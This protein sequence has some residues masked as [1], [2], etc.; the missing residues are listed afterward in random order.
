MAKGIESIP[1]KYML[2][3]IVSVMILGA[4]L[5]ILNQ[6]QATSMSIAKASNTTMT[7][8]LDKSLSGAL[9]RLK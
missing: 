1:L 7:G 3:I 2:L 4:F 5:L 6:L 9:E 8:L